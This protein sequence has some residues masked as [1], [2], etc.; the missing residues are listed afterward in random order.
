MRA[1]ERHVPSDAAHHGT[2]GHSHSRRSINATR[3]IW[4][5]GA[6]MCRA[7]ECAA[8]VQRKLRKEQRSKSGTC[9]RSAQRGRRERR[10]GKSGI[11]D[12]GQKVFLDAFYIYTRT[13]T[14]TIITYIVYSRIQVPSVTSFLLVASLMGEAPEVIQFL[15]MLYTPSHRI[16]L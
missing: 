14:H 8:G 1:N 9:T 10:T 16:D 13:L 12:D 7:I 4:T 15:E 6:R 5:C 3:D 2:R 11:V